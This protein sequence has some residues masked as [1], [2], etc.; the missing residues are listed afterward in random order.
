MGRGPGRPGPTARSRCRRGRAR[1]CSGRG[2]AR[3][4]AHGG[5]GGR[6]RASGRGYERAPGRPTGFGT[7]V[8]VGPGADDGAV[9]LPV[10]CAVCARPGASP[11]AGCVA[12]FERAPPQPVPVGLDDCYALLDYDGPARELVARLKYRNQ[13][14]SVAWLAPAMA[15]LLPAGAIDVVTWAPTTPDRRRHRGFD[16]AAVLA[17]AV[18]RHLGVPCP[19]LLVRRPGLPQT[20]RSRTERWYGPQLTATRGTA[21]WAGA[22]VAVVDDVLTTGASLTAAAA[23]LRSGG[24]GAVVGLVAARTPDPRTS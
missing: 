10:R 20:G 23:A 16:Q 13:R 5:S 24:T 19:R 21:R 22:T 8:P 6:P 12:G 11:C 14:A 4:R 7:P 2:A 17:A 18:G 15:D 9:L 1:W 3:C